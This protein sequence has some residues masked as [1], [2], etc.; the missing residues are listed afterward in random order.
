MPI[1]ERYVWVCTNRREDGNPKGS[2]AQKGSEAL[3]DE[4]KRAVGAA[5]LARTVRVCNSGC[6]DLCEAGMA[7]A[8]MPDNTLLGRV[9]LEDVPALVEG[10]RTPGGTAAQPSLR[11]RVLTAEAPA[12]LGRLA[13]GGQGTEGRRP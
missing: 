11:D 9:S 6:I 1:R 12:A 8:V 13:P 7:V 4:L 2:C 5:G 3:R 10:L